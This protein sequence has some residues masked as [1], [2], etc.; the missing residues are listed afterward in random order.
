VFLSP[1]EDADEGEK[2]PVKLAADLRL[3]AI[4]IRHDLNPGSHRPAPPAGPAAGRMAAAGG[5]FSS[6]GSRA[7]HCRDRE[8]T[9]ELR[10][11]AWPVAGGRPR[12]ARADRRRR[13]LALEVIVHGMNQALDNSINNRG[14]NA[15]H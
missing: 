14:R 8:T 3:F 13:G 4:S 2:A 9:A 10:R 6:F 15:E 11:A 5:A 1:G 7:G 12:V